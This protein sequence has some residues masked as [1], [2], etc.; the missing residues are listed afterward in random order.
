MSCILLTLLKK[1]GT[2]CFFVNSRSEVASGV[3]SVQGKIIRS[4][5]N[6]E[7]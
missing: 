5:G 7:C 3:P 1:T 6:F 2:F 4:S